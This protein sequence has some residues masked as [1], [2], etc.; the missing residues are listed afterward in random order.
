MKRFD[1]SW[2]NFLV[3]IKKKDYNLL[4]KIASDNL[5][6]D[7]EIAGYRERLG[8]AQTN[9]SEKQNKAQEKT[10]ILEGTYSDRNRQIAERELEDILR[11]SF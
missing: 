5:I 10:E 6:N 8:V 2:E 11:S 7:Q 9:L 3:D 1:V 4:E